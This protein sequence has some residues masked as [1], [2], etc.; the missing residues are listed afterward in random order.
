M[1]FLMCN[2]Q[3]PSGIFLNCSEK[4]P[5]SIKE[6]LDEQNEALGVRFTHLGKCLTDRDGD[7]RLRLTAAATP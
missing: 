3:D 4:Y 2:L 7:N 5:S 6:G 1:R